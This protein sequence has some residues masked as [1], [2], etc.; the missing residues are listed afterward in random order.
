MSE[1]DSL[2]RSR[3]RAPNG[4][5]ILHGPVEGEQATHALLSKDGKGDG[6]TIIGAYRTREAAEHKLGERQTITY[7]TVDCLIIECE[8]Y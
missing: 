4:Q 7:P 6:W 2:V 1:T 8:P 5:L 3:F